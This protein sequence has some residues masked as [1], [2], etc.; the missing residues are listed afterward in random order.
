M[1]HE[2]ARFFC[3]HGFSST[4]G[5]ARHAGARALLS[6]LALC[7]GKQAFP[8]RC[9]RYDC[10]LCLFDLPSLVLCCAFYVTLF[11]RC[12]AL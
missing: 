8:I 3:V 2:R 5:A 9:C 1:R 7:A 10:C 6:L 4:D 11:E 12:S